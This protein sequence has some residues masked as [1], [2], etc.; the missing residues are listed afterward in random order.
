MRVDV[1]ERRYDESTHQTTANTCPECDGRVTMNVAETVCDDC[2][3]VL[4]S[5]G[6]DTG[7]EW[8]NFA[9]RDDRL[10]NGRGLPARPHDTTEAS[11]PKSGIRRTHVGGCSRR[12]SGDSCTGF[13]A[14]T[15]VRN[16][17]AR[18]SGMR[19]TA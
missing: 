7:P 14:S 5:N 17:E 15:R 2:G 4:A 1:Y 19:C 8:R 10:G 18:R 13:G 6:V 9:D 16:I 12:R 3:L 11:P